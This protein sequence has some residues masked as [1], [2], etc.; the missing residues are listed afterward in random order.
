MTPEEFKRLP[1]LIHRG[2][3]VAAGIPDEAIDVLR[4]ELKDDGTKVPFGK[5]G[6]I[7]GI[8]RWR[9]RKGKGYWKYRRLDVARILGPGW[10]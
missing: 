8:A 1:P 2:H 10:I 6:A 3:L 9:D 4:V 7:R 5:I